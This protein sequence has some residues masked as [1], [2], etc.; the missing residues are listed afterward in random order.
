MNDI[1]FE[2]QDFQE[3][4]SD[5]VTKDDLEPS[6]IQINSLLDNLE[7]NSDDCS[8]PTNSMELNYPEM[9]SSILEEIHEKLLEVKKKEES[10]KESVDRLELL[11]KNKDGE[12]IADILTKLYDLIKEK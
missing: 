8:S 7:E 4:S 10:V 1:V 2:N 5:N 6:S 3:I 12:N 9:D 11:F